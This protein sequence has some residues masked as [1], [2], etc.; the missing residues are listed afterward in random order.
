MDKASAQCEVSVSGANNNEGN[1][2][3]KQGI[4]EFISLITQ[5]YSNSPQLINSQKR[6]SSNNSKRGT[7]KFVSGAADEE[8]FL[9]LLRK[10]VKE[11]DDMHIEFLSS[12]NNHFF[13]NQK[14]ITELTAET[15]QR[16]SQLDL[17]SSDYSVVEN[18]ETKELK[19]KLEAA[20]QEM[21]LLEQKNSEQTDE[22]NH[23]REL[24][25][26]VSVFFKGN[27]FF[28]SNT[29]SVGE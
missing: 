9:N 4:T 22:I 27:T 10:M 23:L 6:A 11:I 7:S 19:S 1:E 13:D 5:V 25:K 14:N 8:Q 24:I 28:S 3:K 21:S 26:N 2:L 15:S 12:L 20:E 29:L 18:D 17:K 16:F